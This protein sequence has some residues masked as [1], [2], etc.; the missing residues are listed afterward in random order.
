MS[1][2]TSIRLELTE[3]Q[4]EALA[5]IM[6]ATGQKTAKKAV[7]AALTLYPALRK[8]HGQTVRELE[9]VRSELERVRKQR[10][11]LRGTYREAL[12][13]DGEGDNVVP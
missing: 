4:R 8:T 7:V 11:V 9:A 3:E 1:V 10:D 2:A 6:Q 5:E 13:L 12:G